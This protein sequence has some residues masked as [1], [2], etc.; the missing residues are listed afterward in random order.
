MTAN[1]FKD[2]TH[3]FTISPRK[4]VIFEMGLC[5]NCE[6]EVQEP[7]AV[8]MLEPE[9]KVKRMKL[10]KVDQLPDELGYSEE[11]GGAV[12]CDCYNKIEN[13]KKE[14]A[15]KKLQT[16]NKVNRTIGDIVDFVN[17]AYPTH[18]REARMFYVLKAVQPIVEGLGGEEQG[19]TE[20]VLEASVRDHFNW[21]GVK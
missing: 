6:C 21:K 13:E 14:E 15:R 1:L 7:N 17:D 5:E 20:D 3:Y 8:T 11:F 10:E 18:N 4:H 2:K 9:S 19:V 12:C 16:M